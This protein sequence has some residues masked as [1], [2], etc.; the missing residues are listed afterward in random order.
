MKQKTF[1]HKYQQSWNDL[2]DYVNGPGKTPKRT[3]PEEF[4]NL[5]HQ[6][7]VAK[8]RNYSPH[9]IHRLN[10]LVV[11]SHHRFYLH[12]HR[13]GSQWLVFLIWGFPCA[14]RRN[15]NFIYLALALFLVPAM[16]M[17]VACY[18]SEEFIYTF[19]SP[20]EVQRFEGMYDPSNGKV[21]RERGAGDDI[22]MFGFYIKN[23]IGVSFQ[24]FAGGMLFG[25]GSI[26]FMVFNGISIGGVAGHLTQLGYTST[27]WPFVVGHGAFELTAI[28]FS[29]AAGL[30]LGYALINPGASSRLQAVR[31]A[32]RDAIL[33]V[34][35]A[36]IMLV[37]AAFLEAFWSSSSVLPI[38][39]KY[40]VGAL[41]W[42]LVITYCLFSGRRYEFK[43][44]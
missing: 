32:G 4:R 11:K 2:E 24:S 19:S 27:F 8:N 3:F 12:S 39:I 16:A 36:I 34:Y 38:P 22:V 35:G 25:V 29:G 15:A 37:M 21:G 9:L 43:P 13:F 14:L 17:G 5:C 10:D 40:G 44:N 6:L 41:F 7:A 31:T 18:L 33:I 42:I 30:M 23:N 28:V 20:L 1:E 26:F